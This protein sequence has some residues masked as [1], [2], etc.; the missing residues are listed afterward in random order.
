MIVAFAEY[1]PIAAEYYDAVR[2]PTCANFGEL[3][4]LFL[5]PRIQKLA[6]NCQRV[7]EV[8][9][10]RSV[11]A[12][13]LH[14][15]GVPLSRLTLVDTSEGMLSHSRKWVEHGA[16]LMIADARSTGLPDS[17]IDLLIASL[18]DPYHGTDFWREAARILRVGGILLFTTP[19]AEWAERFRSSSIKKSAEFL[20]S[21]DETYLVRS[22][23]PPVAT[24]IKMIEE[25]GLQISEIEVLT[26]KHLRTP[27]SPKLLIGTDSDGE[28]AVVRGYSISR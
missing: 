3:S 4:I 13:I 28:V 21:N 7:V 22:D 23:I 10:G 19:A 9:A 17:S 6:S 27:I 18:G 24:Q 11:A 25:N 14:Q 12:P 1:D 8:G 16:K 26:T 20:L 5:E 15:N 2:H